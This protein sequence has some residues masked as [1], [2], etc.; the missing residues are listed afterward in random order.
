MPN[1]YASGATVMAEDNKDPK[2]TTPLDYLQF[3]VGALY[4]AFLSY[5]QFI[6]NKEVSLMYVAIA[7]LMM[8]LDISKFLSKGK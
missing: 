3:I 8:R 1:G 6:L 2:K 4:L 7:G 5:L